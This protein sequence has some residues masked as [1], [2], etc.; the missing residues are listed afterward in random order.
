M[1]QLQEHGSEYNGEI[2]D[3]D[4]SLLLMCNP[5]ASPE[6]NNLTNVRFLR[7]TDAVDNAV[8]DENC[9]RFSSGCR[10]SMHF[11]R[12]VNSNELEAAHQ[13]QN[14]V[15]SRESYMSEGLRWYP[16]SH[17]INVTRYEPQP[18]D[19]GS[20][21][22]AISQQQEVGAATGLSLQELRISTCVM[23][24]ENMGLA[25]SDFKMGFDTNRICLQTFFERNHAKDEHVNKD[26]YCQMSVSD[27]DPSKDGSKVSQSNNSNTA[28][29]LSSQGSSY[30]TCAICCVEFVKGDPL[31][32]INSCHHRYHVLCLDYWFENNSTC[33]IC[34][35]NL[36]FMV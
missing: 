24:F 29:T 26:K 25:N 13:L 12:S 11:Q 19:A 35:C 23:P 30:K 34:R 32:L 20:L 16:L 6:D 18:F 31:R 14:P 10:S 33:P 36:K 9:T 15:F 28:F 5:I 3:T 4:S 8:D 22:T 2:C 17:I 7:H 27:S 1:H 21:F